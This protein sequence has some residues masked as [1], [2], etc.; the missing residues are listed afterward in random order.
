MPPDVL[1]LHARHDQANAPLV[2]WI[3]A[4][5]DAAAM[6]CALSESVTTR[7]AEGASLLIAPVAAYGWRALTDA[8][9]RA[10]VDVGVPVLGVALGA[11][12]RAIWPTLDATEA[13]R[14][15]L[16]L[17]DLSA[18]SA[19]LLV[20]AARAKLQGERRVIAIAIHASPG[21]DAELRRVLA[22]MTDGSL[23]FGGRAVFQPLIWPQATA[24]RPAGTVGLWWHDTP[25][26]LGGENWAIDEWQTIDPPGALVF[27]KRRPPSAADFD[28]CL[29]RLAREAADIQAFL[30][31]T[32][33]LP[34]LVTMWPRAKAGNPPAD[35]ERQFRDYLTARLRAA[36]G[37]GRTDERLRADT[38]RPHASGSPLDPAAPRPESVVPVPDRFVET[39][40]NER[41]WIEGLCDAPRPSR[42][43]TSEARFA[44]FAAPVEPG[45][46]FALEIGACVRGEYPTLADRARQGAAAPVGA[47]PNAARETGVFDI[48]VDLPGFT[49]TAA[50]PALPWGGWPA[51]ASFRFVAAPGLATGR[52]TGTAVMSLRGVPCVLLDFVFHV[53]AANDTLRDVSL[54]ERPVSSIFA[55]FAPADR[56]WVQRWARHAPR[57]VPVDLDPS[58]SRDATDWDQRLLTVVP[59][60][61]LVCLFW[62]AAAR[63]CL[64]VSREWRCALAARGPRHVLVI[65]L[66]DASVPPELA[67]RRLSALHGASTAARDLT[68]GAAG[69]ELA[70]C[71]RCGEHVRP[72]PPGSVP[73]DERFVHGVE[74]PAGETYFC[75]HCRVQPSPYMDATGRPCLF[76]AGW[77]PF[78]LTFCGYCGAPLS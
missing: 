5:L 63:D 42:F 70:F 18:G 2:A 38:T 41:D 74:P 48:A 50:Q 16:V 71:V 7:R 64:R 15:P 28:Q 76:C 55:S 32:H 75:P 19:D 6:S 53:G 9:A 57:N 43:E 3:K 67:A 65:P 47:R 44:A 30:A 1:I 34:P 24:S 69:Q 20:G 11:A 54:R 61:D 17:P 26:P 49:L 25:T 73:P 33:D 56:E 13:L 40:G 35:F 14:D 59:Q 78:G 77:S 37:A 52:H 66:G 68:P 8:H 29:A 4:T 23:G 36:V 62:S 12:P 39:R 60:V 51:T 27:Y 22:I 10:A 46:T 72:Y 21:L 58:A 45:R 31:R